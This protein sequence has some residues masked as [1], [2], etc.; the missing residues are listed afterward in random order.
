MR[1]VTWLLIGAATMIVVVSLVLGWNLRTPGAVIFQSIGS[2]T[3]DQQIEIGKLI[4]S[5]L[6]FLVILWGAWFAFR[7]FRKERTHTPHIEFAINCNA[8]GSEHGDYLTEIILIAEN[9]GLV[10]QYFESIKLRIRGI[11]E[12]SS[13]NGIDYWRNGYRA[14]F[15]DLLTE[16]YSLTN[17]SFKELARSRV[18]YN[19]IIGLESLRDQNYRTE[20]DFSRAVE[21]KVK[22]SSHTRRSFRNYLGMLLR[23]P[24]QLLSMK[25]VF[26]QEYM[27]LILEYA[28]TS[29]VEVIDKENLNFLFVEPGV[30]QEITYATKIPQQ[31]KYIVAHAVFYYDKYTPHIAEKVFN[32]STLASGNPNHVM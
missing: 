2:L 29:S 24:R 22:S 15:P 14:R 32:I 27:N 19:I 11:D 5:I 28:K 31:Y 8:Y 23:N 25:R 10:I 21:A 13:R 9:K 12:E 17:E 3:V 18:P 20:E 26:S 7:R 1:K 16:S 30:K 4:V 6:Q